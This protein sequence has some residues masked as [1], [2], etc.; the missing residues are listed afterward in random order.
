MK[1]HILRP[2]PE[3]NTI[4]TFGAVGLAADI[5]RTRG[6]KEEF[7]GQQPLSSPFLI[8]NMRKAAELV[9]ECI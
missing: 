7:F 2:L 9:A 6:I 8:N 4:P 3:D 1:R 5:I